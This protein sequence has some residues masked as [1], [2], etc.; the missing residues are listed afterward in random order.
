[1][2]ATEGN[3]Y[4]RNDSA[5]N[6]EYVLS[7][8]LY[9]RLGYGQLCETADRQRILDACETTMHRLVTEPHFARP[10]RFL[11]EEIRSNYPLN[12]QLWI[13]RT[14]ECNIDLARQLLARLPAPTRECAAFTRDGAPCRREPIDGREYCPS[15][16]HLEVLDIELDETAAST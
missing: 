16:R 3:G 15:H 12:E 9:R 7:R 14:I 1:M 4:S 2:S 10:D 13:R 5:E 11:F 8:A 6:A